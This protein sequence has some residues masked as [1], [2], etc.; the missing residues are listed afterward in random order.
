M[1]PN[2]LDVFVT[3]IAGVAILA[4]LVGTIVPAFPG[5]I[6]AWVAIVIFGF[7]VGFTPFGIAAMLVISLLTVV[8]YLIMVRIPKQ[9]A[10][11]RGASRWSTVLGGI[12]ALVGFFVIPVIGFIIGGVVG[13]YASEYYRTK[14]TGQAWHATKGVLI[15]LGKSAAVQL[16][17]GLTIG[18]I[19]FVWVL[20]VFDL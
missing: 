3:I 7:A 12:G 5:I 10:E 14:E 17:I 1:T 20:V 18:A 6:V 19:W 15:G 4:G 2:T 9:E 11:A 16:G 8:N 13:V